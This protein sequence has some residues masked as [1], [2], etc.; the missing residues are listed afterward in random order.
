MKKNSLKYFLLMGTILSLMSCQKNEIEITL[1]KLASVSNLQYVLAGDTVLLTWNLPTGYD[2]LNVTVNDGLVTKQLIMNT[3]SYKFGVVETNHPYRLTVKI[4]DTKGNTSLGETVGFTRDGAA[5]IKDPIAEQNDEGVLVSW[6]LPDKPVTN[7]HVVFGN[8][9]LDLGPTITS[10]QFPDMAA[11]SYLI[12]FITTNSEGQESNTVFFPFRV[13][14][15]MVAYLGVYSDSTTM[16][17]T[18]DDDEIAGAEWLFQNYTRS[19]YISFAQIQN[20]SVDLSQYRVIWWNYDV[21]TGHDLPAIA[22]EASV[23]SKISKYYKDG[24]NLLLS[25]YAIQYFWTLERM[26]EPYFMGFD[27]GTGGE[28]PDIWGIGVNIHQKH[29]QSGHPLF[30]GID[31]TTQGDGRIT[32][33]II[34]AGWKENHNAVVLRIPEYYGMANDDEEAYNRFVND[35]NLE[36]LGMWDGIGDYF[37]SGVMEMKPKDDF[38]GTGL[39]IGIGGIEFHQNTGNPYQTTIDKLYKNAIDY[40]KTK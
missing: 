2:T 36:W 7:I 31:M 34:G 33:P 39:Y 22:T 4:S 32:F 12:S 5:P 26:T 29:D 18:A 21:E 13:G 17:T 35:N 1:T 6:T 16:L 3:T 11:G 30:K 8:Y 25:I 23:V 9:S 19:R 38:Q 24:G 40:L 37:M 10:H 28:N 15:T 20:G 14:P 27:D